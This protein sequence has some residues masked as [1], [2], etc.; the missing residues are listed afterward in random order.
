M[1]SVHRAQKTSI[2]ELFGMIVGGGALVAIL[3]GQF[4]FVAWA[5]GFGW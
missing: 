1:K 5:T 3:S 2:A 4:L